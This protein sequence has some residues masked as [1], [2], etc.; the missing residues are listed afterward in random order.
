MSMQN[1]TADKKHAPKTFWEDRAANAERALELVME[2]IAS[3][4][5]ATRPELES[6]AKEW[7]RIRE[8]IEKEYNEK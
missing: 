2:I 6:V 1:D 3:H 4:L 7:N 8:E 5:P